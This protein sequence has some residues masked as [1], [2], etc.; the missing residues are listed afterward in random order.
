LEVVRELLGR[1]ATVGAADNEGETP[2]YAASCQGHLEVVRELLARGASPG[3]AA[4]V[5]TTALSVATK[6]GHGAI[7]QLLRAALER[8]K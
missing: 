2:L 1:G 5:G 4:N 3:L 6:R 7:A 8:K